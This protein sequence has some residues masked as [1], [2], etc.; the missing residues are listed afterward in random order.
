MD[1]LTEIISA[2]GSAIVA[3][4]FGVVMW[5][6]NRQDKD[7]EEKAKQTQRQL[8]QVLANTEKLKAHDDVIMNLSEALK[9]VMT[10]TDQNSEGVKALMRY[11]LQRY[12][13]TY[14]I[15]GFITSHEKQ[16]YLEAY[17]VYR[18]K[19][20]NGT[21]ESWKREVDTLPVR[22]DV[23]VVNPYIELLKNGKGE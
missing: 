10:A 20:G 14:M 19:G 13:A 15:R 9:E 4:R 18:S 12:H 21:G 3:G 11:L 16:E 6:L 5:H 17:E 22:D 2:C 7:R 23:P 1:T 8:D